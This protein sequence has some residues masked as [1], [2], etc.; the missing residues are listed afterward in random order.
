[1]ALLDD[2]SGAWPCL[3]PV[4]GFPG[5]QRPRP[6]ILEDGVQMR[7][8]SSVSRELQL[9]CLGLPAAEARG[10]VS[11]FGPDGW[12]LTPALGWTLTLWRPTLY[13][14]SPYSRQIVAVGGGI[15]VLGPLCPGVTGTS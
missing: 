8:P 7:F 14:I 2:P 9:C 12:L 4:A 13:G 10:M 6:D 15:Q 11:V 3:C 5:G 1:M